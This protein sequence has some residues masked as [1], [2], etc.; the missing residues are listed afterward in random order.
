[1][2]TQGTDKLSVGE[3]LISSKSQVVDLLS[4]SQGSVAMM[5]IL[6]KVCSCVLDTFGLLS[7]TVRKPRFNGIN[8]QQNTCTYVSPFLWK[9]AWMH[10]MQS[11]I[12][13]TLPPRGPGQLRFKFC[14]YQPILVSNKA[15]A[16]T[17]G[18]LPVIFSARA[19]R[20]PRSREVWSRTQPWVAPHTTSQHLLHV[21]NINI[22]LCVNMYTKWGKWLSPK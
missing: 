2:K 16:Q 20:L 9:E 13:F 6:T 21:F 19:E 17:G 14:C 22:N 12:P 4:G 5:S 8:T 1:M 15:E 7:D 11:L 10:Q 18:W 3:P